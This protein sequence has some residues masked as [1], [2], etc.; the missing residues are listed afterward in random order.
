MSHFRP[1]NLPISSSKANHRTMLRLGMLTLLVGLQAIS[2][3]SRSATITRLTQTLTSIRH[4]VTRNQQLRH[5]LP[6]STRMPDMITQGTTTITATMG[7]ITR[8]KI[9]QGTTT[10]TRSLLVGLALLVIFVSTACGFESSNVGAVPTVD[11]I[12]LQTPTP[13]IIYVTVV[14]T[15]TTELTTQPTPTIKCDFTCERHLG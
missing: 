1:N 9:T 7:M 13:E 2:K 15:A 4:T 8:L 10:K 14:V 12:P 5:R 3:A 6:D 11:L